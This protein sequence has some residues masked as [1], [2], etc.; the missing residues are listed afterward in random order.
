MV[1][2]GLGNRLGGGADVQDQRA[3]VGHLLGQ[4]TR[5]A[6]LAFGVEGFALSVSQVLDRR[7]GYAHPAMKTREQA[8]FSQALYVAAHGL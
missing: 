2:Q 7:A 3:V 4:G 5:N 1:Q 8:R 6:G